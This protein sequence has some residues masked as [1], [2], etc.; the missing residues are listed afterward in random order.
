MGVSHANITSII[1]HE[2]VIIFK[3]FTSNRFFFLFKKEI[4]SGNTYTIKKKKNQN[5]QLKTPEQRQVDINR[6][7]NK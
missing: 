1:T 3:S 5:M 2:I 7:F 4:N 6:Y